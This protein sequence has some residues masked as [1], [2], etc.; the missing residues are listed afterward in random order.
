MFKIEK[1]IPIPPVNRKVRRKP[2]SI[3]KCLQT[4][5]VNE[6]FVVPI[7]EGLNAMKFRNQIG[8]AKSVI[9]HKRK[10]NFSI[11]TRE[12]DGGIR[13]WRVE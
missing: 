2:N 3:T 5:E 10:D 11:I 9:K 6:S 7:P 1:N 12:V 8:Y 4:L 13:I